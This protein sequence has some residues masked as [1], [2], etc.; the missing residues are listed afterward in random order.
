MGRLPCVLLGALLAMASAWAPR[1]ARSDE[2]GVP[3]AL[4]VELLDRLLWYERSLQKSPADPLSVWV[5]MRDGDKESARTAA[6]LEAQFS[7]LKSL[8]GRRFAQQT[9]VFAT[10]EQLQQTVRTQTPYLLYFAQGFEDVVGAVAKALQGT[11]ALTVSAV[12][13]D[14]GR[15]AVL[16]FEL[17]SSKPRIVLDLRRAR[18][19][20][21]DFSAQL[22]RIARVIQ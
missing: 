15:G 8:G 9:I 18:A 20:Q 13:G 4:Q 5:V 14:V 7:R 2:V 11:R 3:V 19:Q 17:A 22:L 21:M 12:G 6:Q 1:R 10:A 16:S